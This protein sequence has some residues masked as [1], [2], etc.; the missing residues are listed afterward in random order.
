M[1]VFKEF[2]QY[3]PLGLAELVRNRELTSKDLLDEVIRRAELANV[4]INALINPLFDMALPDLPDGLFSGV[5]FC[6]K[7]CWQTLKG[8]TPV[9]TRKLMLNGYLKWIAN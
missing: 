1:S 3:D 4:K 8:S 6:L 2:H 7:I 9:M 5:P